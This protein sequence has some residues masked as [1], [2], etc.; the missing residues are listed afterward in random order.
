MILHK[1]PVRY[2]MHIAASSCI[3]RSFQCLEN[4]RSDF[5]LCAIGNFLHNSAFTDTHCP[6]YLQ[7][8]PYLFRFLHYSPSQLDPN[9]PD[10]H[11]PDPTPALSTNEVTLT[12]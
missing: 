9:L 11:P 5:C 3:T 4:W 1:L 6:L 10:L 8:L 12:T 2:L 7:D